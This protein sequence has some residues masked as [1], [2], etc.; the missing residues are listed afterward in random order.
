MASI[1]ELLSMALAQGQQQVVKDDPYA[2][3]AQTGSQIGNIFA[4]ATTNPNLMKGNGT[5]DAILGAAISGLFGGAMGGLSSNYQADRTSKYNDLLLGAMGGQ[6]VTG[7]RD[8]TSALARTAQTEAEKFKALQGFKEADDLRALKNQIGL[9]AGATLSASPNNARDILSKVLGVNVAEPTPI[10]STP[11]ENR[12]IEGSMLD[13]IAMETNRLIEAGLPPTQAATTARDAYSA[14]KKELMDSY[15]KVDEAEKSGQALLRMTD[16][17][18]S[19]VQGA[20]D[21]GFAG[22]IKQGIAGILGE[23]GSGSQAQKYA[24]GKEVQS[25]GA[26]IV[27]NAR[28]IG[29]GPMSDKDVQMY[30]QSGPSLTNPEETNKAIIERMRT[31]GQLQS[32]YAEFMRNQRELGVP[33]NKAEQAWSGLVAENPYFIR[34]EQTGTLVPNPAWKESFGSTATV[35]TSAITIADVENMTPEQAQAL[36]KQIGQ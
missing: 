34:N 28:Q 24:S 12:G 7:N 10:V 30:L 2:G 6:D 5:R 25:L 15:A 4:Q 8:V 26:E 11:S 16:Q 36:L 33:V 17:L 9:Q 14:R 21:T 27:R 13:D 3:L 20:G 29:S 35:P 1:E 32:K 19:A 22:G 31:A 23:F 18:E